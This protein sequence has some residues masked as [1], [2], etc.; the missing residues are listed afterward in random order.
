MSDTLV[1][2]VAIILAVALLVVIPLQVTSQRVDTMSKLDVDT[3][4]SNFVD[5]IRTEGALTKDNYY[6][7]K[8]SLT[9]TGN[10][11][12]VNMEF[13]IL[14][15]NPGKKTTQTERDKIGENVYYSVY[16]S[17]IEEALENSDSNNRYPLKQG[18]MISVTVRNTNLTIGQQLKNF[19]YKV[20]GNDTY[21][22]SS[23]K[24][25]MIVAND[26][27]STTLS[28][29]VDKPELTV[30]LRE[31]DANGKVITS[32]S[33][34]KTEITNKWTNKNVYVEMSS[35]DN[36]N[37]NLL[38]FI[39]NKINSQD[40]L[41]YKQLEGNNYT[42]T[43][44]GIRIYQAFWKASLLEKYSG[45][46]NI[47]IRIDRI[48]PTIKSATATSVKGNTGKV[49][50]DAIDN[51]GSGINGYYYT[52]TD[53]N[54]TPSQPSISDTN[55]QSSNYVTAYPENNNKKCT[56]WVKDNAGNISS[57]AKAVVRNVV[58][59]ITK[60][61]LQNTIIKT[62]DTKSISAKLTGGND[63][64]DIRFE[65]SNN[66][67]VS[68]ASNGTEAK[69][70]GKNPGKAT[71]KCTVTNYDGTTQTA[72]AVVSVTNVEFSPNG[73]VDKLVY[74]DNPDQIVLKTNVKV[75]GEPK[76]LEY[77]WANSN[78]QEP[79]NW[80]QFYSGQE[81]TNTVNKIGEYYLWVRVTDDYN[82]SVTYVSK[83][84]FV[85]YQVPEASKYIS[86]NYSTKNWTNKDVIIGLGNSAKDFITQISTDGKTWT[87]ANTYTFTT[88]GS[89]FVRLYNENTKDAGSMMTVT[90]N[91]IDK[92][93]PKIDTQLYNKEKTP[94]SVT[95]ELS[96]SDSNSGFSKVIWYYKTSNS[97]QYSK[98]EDVDKEM[99]SSTSG[100]TTANIKSKTITGLT[101]GETYNLYAEVY[102][103]AGNAVRTPQKGTIDVSLSKY[104][105]TLSI[106]GTS[107]ST[108][109]NK[110]L[111]FTI[112]SNPSGG[113]VSVSSSDTSV[114][115]VS[116][117]NGTVT[118]KPVKE[119]TSTITVTS[120]A[121]SDY[122]SATKTYTAT[123]TGHSKTEGGS[124][125]SAATCTSAAVYY[126]KCS[127]CGNDLSSIYSSG[128]P[129]GHDLSRSEKM[130]EWSWTENTGGWSGA[131]EHGN[132]T[133]MFS[134]AG[135]YA[136]F[137][138]KS[139]GAHAM[140]VLYYGGESNASLDICLGT[141]LNVEAGGTAFRA[142]ANGYTQFW[143]GGSVASTSNQGSSYS[144]EVYNSFIN[145][146]HG[147]KGTWT[148]TVFA[149]SPNTGAHPASCTRYYCSRCSYQEDRYSE[150]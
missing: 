51:G 140:R 44:E 67:I 34:D 68:I 78:S 36:Y 12:D 5:Q 32:D 84:F 147:G 102:D 22:I 90:I 112:T 66:S 43:Q 21:T 127:I 18:D 107:G 135:Q 30:T 46:K 87:T 77:S 54:Q 106:S 17:Q 103:V 1:T 63:Y 38:Y 150:F 41:N 108:C 113:K 35:K 99:N 114:A 74:G 47:K 149:N 40:Y 3:L 29:N 146:G 64:R 100:S 145:W 75:Y 85:K 111:T 27:T 65:T 19:A 14:D 142:W 117:S 45:I 101:T 143:S 93:L 89:L 24:S 83:R 58:Y 91:N 120:A 53:E 42:E 148:F 130:G 136:R 80:K 129:L 37:L 144:N 25:G 96:A 94:S 95:M 139:Y 110:N 124:L 39:R 141:S 121:T 2:V 4:T 134:S 104:S 50:V 70:T 7:F 131:D 16:T 138:Y 97:S 81:I 105:G 55:W 76:R 11:Y 8:Q 56:V 118:I 86:I 98:I 57:A 123:I 6:S 79:N 128:S 10:T 61:E 109:T 72:T 92:V 9:S 48:A 33:T 71:I 69:I 28:N 133:A 26:A 31:N 62:G 88:N 126:Y 137:T 59:P 125:K 119:G 116:I 60:V 20:T 132:K 115:T 15:E 73:K 13:K 49:T 23:S 82:N 52:W 122:E